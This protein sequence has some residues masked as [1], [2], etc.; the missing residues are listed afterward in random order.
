MCCYKYDLDRYC[1]PR[2]HYHQLRGEGMFKK[3]FALLILVFVIIRPSFATTTGN[4]TNNYSIYIIGSTTSSATP[5]VAVGIGGYGIYE[6][7]AL[8]AAIT[9]LTITGTIPDGYIL[10]LVI[11]DNGTARALTFGTSFKSTT[12]T[13]PT[14]T[15]ISTPIRIFFQYDATSTNW[16]CVGTA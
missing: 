10:E 12:V 4:A 1:K 9:S 15:V 3:L 6:I 13:I 16:Y 11:T 14:T 2:Q 7:T 8:A 5:S